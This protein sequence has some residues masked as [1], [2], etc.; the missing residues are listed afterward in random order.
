[1]HAVQYDRYGGGPAGLKV[2]NFVNI[3]LF[4]C[5]L[6]NWFSYH[7]F[8]KNSARLSG[9]N[10]KFNLSKRITNPVGYMNS[11]VNIEHSLSG[12]S[13][14]HDIRKNTVTFWLPNLMSLL[15]YPSPSFTIKHNNIT[16]PNYH[17]GPYTIKMSKLP[18]F[19]FSCL[20]FYRCYPY[21][22][23]NFISSN[24]ISQSTTTCPSP[25][26]PHLDPFC[27]FSF[28]PFSFS[29]I[30]ERRRQTSVE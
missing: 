6:S 15:V 30:R 24:S 25:R 26:S 2:I 1:M 23:T 13:C 5:F 19:I 29:L 12:T 14:F 9:M 4:G 3:C 22:W 17:M 21:H 27:T 16:P 10:S 28:K 7:Q 11:V 20:I 18:K 8:I